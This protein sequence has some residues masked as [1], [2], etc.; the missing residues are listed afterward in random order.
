MRRLFY[1]LLLVPVFLRAQNDKLPVKFG[2]VTQEDFNINT[3]A[4]DTSAGA[5]VIADFGTSD[6]DGKSGGGMVIKFRHSCRIKILKH[7]AFDA[8]TINIPLYVS[9]RDY[10]SVEGLR[11]S[12]YNLEN[13]QVV[14]TKLDDKMVFT[15]KIDKRHTE[16][17]FTFPALKE[18]SIVEYSYTQ[19][20]PFLFNL[21]PWKF[22]SEYPCLWSEYQAGIP[23]FL[24]Y[25]TMSHGYVPFS[26]NSSHSAEETF[27]LS[28]GVLRD[29]VVTHR[30][31]TR[32]VP[33]FK[34]E[35]F[36]TTMDNYVTSIEFQL[37]AVDHH[38]GSTR[39]FMGSW[40]TVDKE[41][42]ASDDFGAD[43]YRNNDWLDDDLTT[44]VK[45]STSP[46]G[47]A[48]KIYAFV[49]DNFTCTGH[50]SLYITEP[51][52]T[53]YKNRHGNEAELNLL[54]TAMLF[55]LK[56]R[57]EPTILSTRKHGFTVDVY[58]MLGRFN[59]VISR[60]AIDSSWI[61]LD[62]SEPWLSFGKLPGRCYNGHARI[63]GKDSAAYV[64]LEADSLMEKKMTV[65]F[66]N[67]D[68]K[69]SLSGHLQT[70]PG[71][72]EACADREKL[73]STN[74]A[75]F[76]KTLNVASSGEYEISGLEID[77]LRKP[78]DPLQL[79]YDLKITPDSNADVFYF[80]PMLG[81]GYK[82]NPFQSAQRL[83]PVEMSSASDDMFMLTMDIPEGYV[84]DEMPKPAK[85][86]FNDNEGFFE[87]LLEK[88]GDMI[89]F[90]SR[91]KLNKANF[92]PEDYATLRDF[93]AFIVKKQNEQIV[94]KKKKSV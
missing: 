70:T 91:I 32:D 40:N 39:D 75:D 79:A 27:Y 20:S 69:A 33:P 63:I 94:F 4:V 88:N 72:L 78:D 80:S 54:L 24:I 15:D 9:G 66:I 31:V 89:Q 67:R 43:I 86:T 34:A 81:G 53:I 92:K 62:A 64:S 35:P 36:T 37:S 41:L 90:R 30:W 87:Y 18:G 52:Q 13:G 51:I 50:N 71:F 25:I 8:A 12:T 42:L 57:A 82:E 47:K 2:K 44:I 58:P 60:V 85:V 23:D 38:N 84:V 93:F 65:A 28:S 46:L 10:E 14:E 3:A 49:R 1:L 26:V 7:T 61:Y 21:Q 29:N 77:S 17:K 59:Y 19:V 6:F 16:K 76:I 83:Y 45:G 11:A 55:H 74:E 22:Q 68:G 56:I 48:M 5:V 73:R